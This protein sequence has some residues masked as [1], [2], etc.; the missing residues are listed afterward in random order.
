MRIFAHTDDKGFPAHEIGTSGIRSTAATCAFIGM[1]ERARDC[2]KKNLHHPG[3]TSHHLPLAGSS[4]KL[5][6]P[7]AA[8]R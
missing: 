2:S 8:G 3:Q 7:I 4:A 6:H 5:P 1:R